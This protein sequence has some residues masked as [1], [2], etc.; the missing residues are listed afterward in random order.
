MLYITFA[1]L[2]CACSHLGKAPELLDALGATLEHVQSNKRELILSVIERKIKA[3]GDVL[4]K[5]EAWRELLADLRLLHI[6]HS[7]D[8]PAESLPLWES[9]PAMYSVSTSSKVS[10]SFSGSG[11]TRGGGGDPTL[12][13]ALATLME[14]ER[15][16][17]A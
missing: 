2:W 4:R 6:A 9:F 17:P 12:T 8:C 10:L 13:V 3:G 7:S 11:R 16:E 1:H 14:L 5:S 15:L